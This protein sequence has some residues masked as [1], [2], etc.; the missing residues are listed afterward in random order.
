[1]CVTILTN[2]PV[3][4]SVE[5]ATA[6]REM[7][8]WYLQYGREDDP[9]NL[10]RQCEQIYND[11]PIS[12][13]RLHDF[14]RFETEE[15]LA[16]ETA[17][18]AADFR[19]APGPETMTEFFDAAKQYLDAAR[20]G[21]S[22]M[23]DDWRVSNLADACVDQLAL[24]T[25]PPNSA[26]TAF[27]RNTLSQPDPA[28]GN[29]MA[30]GFTV[31]LC[32][33]HLCAVK[34]EGN[35]AV[36]PGLARL[37]DLAAAKPRLLWGLYGNVHP[38]NA[39]TLT[40]VELN[41]IL[42]YEHRF[43]VREWFILLG[44]FYTVDAQGVQNRL[45]TRLDDMRDDPIESSQCMGHFIKSVHITARRYDWPKSQ[46]PVEWIID[47][48]IEF[49]LDGA[50]L[51]MYDLEW[52]RDQAGFRLSMVKLT[53]LISSRIKLEESPKPSDSFEIVPHDF[54]I[55]TW[56]HFDSDSQVEVEAFHEFCQMALGHSFTAIYW[57]PKYVVQLD[58]LGQQ[59]AEYVRKHLADT[60]DINGDSLARLGYLASVYPDDSDAWA[61]IALPI[62][63]KAQ[64]FRR[65]DREHV[66]FGLAQKKTGVL[67]SMPGEVADY[68]VQRCD[69]AT[70]LL[71]AEP[72]R[73]PLRPYRKWVLRCAER[74]LRLEKGKAE[75]DANG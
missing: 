11:L 73:S 32:R 46:L 52:L 10:A 65:E 14:F 15:K 24:Y 38:N 34:N 17:R 64:A 16:P 68:Y 19:N 47:M 9:V 62:C 59:V 41:C 74:D 42:S 36:A 23:A 60:P 48:I 27:V 12:R 44:A 20:R 18:V 69:S 58:P 75:E 21:L 33:R 7:W 4:L 6:A 37:L 49:G 70:H 50:L 53:D 71:S 22:D 35:A 1:M 3:A 40:G 8:K 5:E 51:G 30:W 45:R 43:S 54:A 31:R 13:W 56:A 55:G 63:V 25:N 72:P 28:Q 29:A 26:V 66:Y 57:M 2:P 67:R 39:G 61:S